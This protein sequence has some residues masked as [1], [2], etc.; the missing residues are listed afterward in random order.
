MVSFQPDE[1]RRPMETKKGYERTS[2]KN[3]WQ[4]YEMRYWL[5]QDKLSYIFTIC[6]IAKEKWSLIRIKTWKRSEETRMK[7]S[8]KGK[9]KFWAEHSSARGILNSEQR[10]LSR[11]V[12]ESEVKIFSI[13]L[14]WS[15]ANGSDSYFL[16]INSD[17]SHTTGSQ[18]DC[19]SLTFTPNS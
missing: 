10:E 12:L 1:A 8:M 5:G 13:H 17:F 19:C 16:C 4:N 7:A 18:T 2:W 14:S 6:C 9:L 3:A 11:S 15:R